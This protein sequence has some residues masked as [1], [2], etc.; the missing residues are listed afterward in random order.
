MIK[1]EKLFKSFDGF[2]VLKN[3]DL[4]I[5]K[6]DVF[7][8]IGKSGSGK[9]TLLRCINGIESFEK[10]SLFINEIEINSLS[11]S[12]LRKLKKKIGMVYQSFSLLTQLNV[13]DNVALPMRC[14]GYSNKEI[15]ERVDYL[16][17]LVG[18]S[19]KKITRSTLLSGGQ[20][21][22]VAIARALALDPDILLCDEAT[23]ALDPKTTKNILRLLRDINKNLGI[24]LIV[25][26]HEMDVIKSITDKV[27]IIEDG[28]VKDV[29]ITSEIFFEMPPSLER[30][31]AEDINLY[32]HDGIALQIFFSNSGDSTILSKLSRKFDFDVQILGGDFIADASSIMMDYLTISVPES[33]YEEL[34]E[35][36]HDHEIIWKR[37]NIGDSNVI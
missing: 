4:S 13:Y 9:S 8:I 1:I 7:G 15:E 26:T 34:V 35:Y 16:L 22:R 31:L 12:E 2:S 5:N 36:L 24:T 29:G 19:D 33:I 14:W 3:I 25:V 10:G 20:Q 23:S 17:E 11:D 28:L 30:L 37:I 32:D 21:Q 18:L 6:G 27:A